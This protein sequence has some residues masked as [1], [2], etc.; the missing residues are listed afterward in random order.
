MST[1]YVWEKYGIESKSVLKKGSYQDYNT[2]SFVDNDKIEDN[3]LP[4]YYSN[5]YSVNDGVV[6]L[7]S[8]QTKYVKLGS[9]YNYIP[10]GNVF[11]TSGEYENVN[12][13]DIY[14]S[15]QQTQVSLIPEGSGHPN[16][17]AVMG[18]LYYLP[19][20]SSEQE[21]GSLTGYASSATDGAYPADGVSGNVCVS[22]RPPILSRTIP[23]RKIN[24]Y[25]PI[26][27][28]VLAVSYGE[29]LGHFDETA[30]QDVSDFRGQDGDVNMPAS[31]Q[32]RNAIWFV[33]HLHGDVDAALD[34]QIN[35]GII[36]DVGNQVDLPLDSVPGR[37]CG[38]E[39]GSVSGITVGIK[40]LV[41][42]FGRSPRGDSFGIQA[43]LS[44]IES[45]THVLVTVHA[46]DDE[47]TVRPQL[48]FGD[49]QGFL[50]R[51]HIG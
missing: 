10:N 40:D 8:P 32:A 39:V 41:Y 25:Q 4:V 21:K 34:G 45:L 17:Y 22:K 11:S 23:R 13:A 36:A 48:F 44:P 29:G 35:M 7:I 18:N 1:R 37:V 24:Q 31:I 30:A 14:L 15:G 2:L 50:W 12:I 51:N 20:V 16:Q 9:S 47:C 19:S 3:G 28:I 26:Q 43:Q 49:A 6:T 42:V 38:H 33:D 27:G 5:E 46:T